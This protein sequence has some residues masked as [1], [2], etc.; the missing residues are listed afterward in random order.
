MRFVEIIWAASID[1]RSED[2]ALGTL[3][4]WDWGEKEEKVGQQRKPRVRDDKWEG[5]LSGE[6]TVLEAK[7]KNSQEED[8][9]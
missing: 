7:G 8:G 5:K 9:G 3:A 6:C 4:Y 2:G 1:K